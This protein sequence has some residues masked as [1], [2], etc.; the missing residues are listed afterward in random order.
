M[1]LVFNHSKNNQNY[2]AIKNKLN[3]TIGKVGWFETTKYDDNTPVA[4]VA[5]QNEFGSPSKHIPSRSFMRTSREEHAKEWESAFEQAIKRMDARTAIE[6]VCMK[7]Q[8]DIRK[9][10]TD[11]WEPPLSTVTIQNRWY[12]TQA[13]RKYLKE[14]TEFIEGKRKTEPKMNAQI[15]DSF[16]KP[17]IDTGFMI[18]SLT[19][20]VEGGK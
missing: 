5:A 18:A 4:S 9:K 3:K 8:G 12:K 6:L 13:G 10:I 14:K 20:K 2:E 11:I 19:H 15:T 7:A 16:K 17:L 1:K